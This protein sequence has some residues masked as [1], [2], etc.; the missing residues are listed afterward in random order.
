[1]PVVNLRAP[2]ADL[3]GN[4]SVQ[5]S[6]DTVGEVIAALE[7]NHPKAKGWVLDEAGAIRRH[8][9]VFLDG[10]RV[11]ADAGVASDGAIDIIPAISGGS[12]DA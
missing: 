11:S 6:G 7:L 1:M 3:V 10:E 4:R 8:I 9:S 2:L 12:R 5:L